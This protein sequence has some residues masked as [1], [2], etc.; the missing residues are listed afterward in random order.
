[1]GCCSFKRPKMSHED[2]QQWRL[3]MLNHWR[4]NLDQRLA[5]IDAS[6]K[7]LEEQIQRDATERLHNDIKKETPE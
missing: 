1:M 4:D 7:K 2:H 5:G 3:K 6:I